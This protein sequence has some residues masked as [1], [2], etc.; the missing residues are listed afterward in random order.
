MSQENVEIV[1]QTFAAFGRRDLDAV[2]ATM[3]PH[4]LVR[5]DPRWPEQ[6]VYGRE[7]WIA[8]AQGL[9]ESGGLTSALRRSST[10]GIEFSFAFAGSCGG[11][12]AVSRESSA[13]RKSSPFASAAPSSS[14]TSL[15]TSRPSKRWRCGSSHVLAEPGPRALD[16]RGHGTR[17]LRQLG[18]VGGPRG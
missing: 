5:T 14:S 3:D 4:V 10:S 2:A 18:R 12:T 11:S 13:P 16:L 15:S 7:A 1:K 8:W 6:H 17:R 9:L